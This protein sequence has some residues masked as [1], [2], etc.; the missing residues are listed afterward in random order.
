LY[1]LYVDE[2]WLSDLTL[3]TWRQFNGRGSRQ[4]HAGKLRLSVKVI[5]SAPPS[6]VIKNS[7]SNICTALQVLSTYLI[8][9]S[10]VRNEE[11][12]E[13]GSAYYRSV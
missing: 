12:V 13:F 10:A 3:S 1:L 8:Q 7:S 2:K 4:P 9:R 5:H 6:A 11:Q